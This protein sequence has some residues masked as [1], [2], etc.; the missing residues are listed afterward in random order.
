MRNVFTAQSVWS[1]NKKNLRCF[2][3]LQLIKFL[4]YFFNPK[5]FYTQF[6]FRSDLDLFAVMIPKAVLFS[7][8][9]QGSSATLNSKEKQSLW[10]EFSTAVRII[11]YA[12]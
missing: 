1:V 4:K 11:K 5:S 12:K 10:L 9:V 6:G 2:S 7:S 8:F 3:E